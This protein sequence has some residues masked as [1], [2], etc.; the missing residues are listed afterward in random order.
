MTWRKDEIERLTRN[1]EACGF[2]L[3]AERGKL[4]H[5]HRKG[6]PDAIVGPFTSSRDAMIWFGGYRAGRAGEPW[7]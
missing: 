6:N 2:V 7:A 4:L 1:A 3:V 5:A